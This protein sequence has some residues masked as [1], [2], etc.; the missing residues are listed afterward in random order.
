MAIRIEPTA[1]STIMKMVVEVDG[2]VYMTDTFSD[3]PERAEEIAEQVM[4]RLRD[5]LLE[6]VQASYK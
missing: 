1:D 6:K 2:K 3:E 5:E 4:D